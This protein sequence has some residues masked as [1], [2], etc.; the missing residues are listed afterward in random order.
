MPTMDSLSEEALQTWARNPEQAIAHLRQLIEQLPCHDDRLQG[1]VT[2]TLENCGTPTVEQLNELRKIFSSMNDEQAYWIATLI[3]R[4]QRQGVT[5]SD[6]LVNILKRSTK[7]IQSKLR[8]IWAA[9]Q[10]GTL[11]T[12]LRDSLKALSESGTSRLAQ[13]ANELL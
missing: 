8:A 10:I 13:A 2:E 4:M 7:D 9:K 3:G 6:L 12:E 1:W 11:S 5:A